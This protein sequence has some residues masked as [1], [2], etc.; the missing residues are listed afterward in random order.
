MQNR[1]SPSK[2][3]LRAL[4]TTFLLTAA[5]TF[6]VSAH[7]D[8]NFSLGW[9]TLSGGGDRHTSEHYVIEGIHGQAAVGNSDT[10]TS[11][12]LLRVVGGFFGPTNPTYSIFL[13]SMER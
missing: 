13:P 4:I 2:K 8:A 5:F 11:Q 1:L 9:S 12:G 6:L 10:T 3:F 7:G